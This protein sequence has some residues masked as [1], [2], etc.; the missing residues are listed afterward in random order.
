MTTALILAAGKG[1]RCWP[2][3]STRP[4]HLLPVAN[5]PLALRLHRQLRAA[6]VKRVVCVIDASDKHSAHALPGVE[7]LEVSHSDSPVDSLC[8]ALEILKSKEQSWLTLAGDCLFSD[9]D[10]A[11]LSVALKEGQTAV[12]LSPLRQSGLENE[13][14]SNQL[15]AEFENEQFS[16]FIAH[17]RGDFDFPRHEWQLR[18]TAAFVLNQENIQTLKQT[19]PYFRN[20]ET[21]MMPPAERLIEQTINDLMGQGVAINVLQTQQYFVDVDKPWQL[22]AAND[23]A[24]SQRCEQID[25]SLTEADLPAGSHLRGK[26]RLGKNSRIEG[27]VWIEGNLWV[28]DDTVISNGVTI[29]GN[30]VV[31][32][33]V[34]LRDHCLVD[35]NSSLGDRSFVGHGAE[36][37]G[38]AM[39]NVYLYHYMEIYGVLGSNTDIGAAT[40]CGTLRFDD[41]DT[42]H[43]INGRSE[44]ASSH[45][46]A[47]FLGDFCRT[48]VNAILQPGVKVGAYSVI[49]PGV[50]LNQDVPDKTCIYAK[51]E[52]LTKPWGPEKY[53]W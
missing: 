16:G 31:G 7:L 18:S 47:S 15:V 25:N 12:M 43:K 39:E 17:P 44:Q 48:G 20:I 42:R 10:I 22:L 49:G 4:K 14:A 38:L 33:Q 23:V 9:Q 32:N 5:E 50:M 21:G 11:Q 19:P 46:N 28:G 41:S 1:S 2:Y 37:C 40:V 8:Q 24:V 6:G 30:A 26:L 3:S 27:T 53:G 36:F 34:T 45:A 29:R 52:L 35:G 13:P 51:Q